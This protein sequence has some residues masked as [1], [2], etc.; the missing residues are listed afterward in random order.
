M[1]LV[2]RTD[3]HI[4]G[5]VWRCRRCNKKRNVRCN[6]IFAKIP[7]ISLGNAM[8]FIYFWSEDTARIRT[9][10]ALG[11]SRNVV[12]K[13]YRVLE[14]VCSED[15]SAYP[16]ILFGVPNSIVQCDESKFNHKPKYNRG[17]RNADVWVFG[18]VTTEFQRTRGYYSQVA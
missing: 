8:L 18:I 6:N 1:L 15:I 10:R 14:D 16:F 17:R 11:H 2:R 4:D 5:Y 12:G 3:N 9:A 13:F 7:K